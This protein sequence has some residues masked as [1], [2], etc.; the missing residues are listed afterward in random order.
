M[1]EAK[2]MAKK[3]HPVAGSKSTK[4]KGV[5]TVSNETVKKKTSA[6]QKKEVAKGGVDETADRK[7]TVA[8]ASKTKISKKKN[9]ETELGKRKIDAEPQV[10]S[11]S[12]EV[13]KRRQKA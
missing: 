9:E 10:T 3:K 6:S 4:R 1:R 12:R 13:K 7:R 2:G 8:R 11:N 5:T